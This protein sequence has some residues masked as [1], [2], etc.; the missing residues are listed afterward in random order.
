MGTTT[1]ARLLAVLSQ[2]DRTVPFE[3]PLNAGL[4]EIDR[5]ID[6]AMGARFK[7]RVP[8]E[9]QL[10]PATGSRQALE[11]AMVMQ[12]ELIIPGNHY[13]GLSNQE[14]LEV[15]QNHGRDIGQDTDAIRKHLRD[16]LVRE[17]S[18]KP[19]DEGVAG[20]LLQRLIVQWVVRRVEEQGLDVDLAPLSPAYKSRKLKQG[21]DGRIGIRKGKWLKA[22][23]KARVNIT[24]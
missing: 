12:W 7:K 17:F 14:L 2:H 13:S 15:F 8:L 18:G 3:L 23:R 6:A 10:G 4:A 24:F 9:Q 11:Y 20:Q 19:W 1:L 5:A 21:Y 16:E 22:I